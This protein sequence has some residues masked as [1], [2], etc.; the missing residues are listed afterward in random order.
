MFDGLH[1]RKA[2][3]V[4]AERLREGILTR[5]FEPGASLPNERALADMSGLSR[6]SVREALCM[7][8]AEGLIVTRPGRGGGSVPHLPGADTLERSIRLFIRGQR[9]RL[10]SLLEAREAIEPQLARLAAR[11]CTKEDLHQLEQI[12]TRFEDSAVLLSELAHMNVDWHLAVAAASRNELL[13]GVWKAVSS[14]MHEASA[15]DVPYNS[16]EVRSAV[17]HAHR[18]ILDAI[19]SGDEE[20]AARRMARHLGAY[21]EHIRAQT[22]PDLEL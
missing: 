4:L 15:I 16:A 21:V 12:Q 8:E 7:L 9:I 22:P 6:A 17:C 18:R 2:S 13:T 11:N 5:H 20:A 10:V 3:A 14:L 19:A 1:A